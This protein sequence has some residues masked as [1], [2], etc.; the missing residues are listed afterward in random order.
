M[1]YKL[2]RHNTSC[3]NKNNSKVAL[4]EDIDEQTKQTWMQLTLVF[5]IVYIMDDLS[6]CFFGFLTV[7]WLKKAHL[8]QCLSFACYEL[9]NISQL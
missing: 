2:P 6:D 5:Q 9:A 7:I 4:E 1:L 3:T 8:T